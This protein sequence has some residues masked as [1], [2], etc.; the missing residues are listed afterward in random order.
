MD[1]FSIY[2]LN[3]NY[4]F[5]WTIWLFFL[6]LLY[7]K[8]KNINNFSFFSDIKKVY[9]N[10]YNFYTKIIVIMIIF[11]L[12]SVIF[13]NP[14]IS[15]T[16][17]N[18]KKDWIDIVIALDISYSMEANDFSPTRMEYAKKVLLDFIKTQETNRIWLVVFAWKPFTSIPLTF[19]YN[20]LKEYVWNLTVNSINQNM[21][22]LSWTAIWDALLMSK[23]LFDL[24][25]TEREKVIILL[26]DWDANVWVD[27]VAATEF[28]KWDGIKI[29]SIWVWSD[30]WGEIIVWSWFFEQRYFVEPL[31]DRDL[32]IIS[33]MTL[34]EYFLANN[35]KTF[36]D[37]FRYLEWLEKNEIEVEEKREFKSIYEFFVFPLIVLLFLFTFFS[38][39]RREL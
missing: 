17:E 34:W 26:T 33:S 27:P 1:F 16:K 36:N 21:P 20:I 15:N 39:Y 30:D 13:S 38:L 25:E 24:D 4:F 19:D 32:K 22:W 10:N 23:N 9:T 11:L 29:Y 7:F 2:F 8:Y 14:N 3:F 37:I 6:V 5:V 28:I 31:N 18:I 35:E 12:Y